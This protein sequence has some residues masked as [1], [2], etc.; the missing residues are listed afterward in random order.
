[1]ADEDMAGFCIE[2]VAT[3]DDEMLQTKTSKA[4]QSERL[5]LTESAS[6]IGWKFANQGKSMYWL[7]TSS[8]P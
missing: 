6:G 3:S 8:R 5:E 4:R 2:S 1:M 7:G